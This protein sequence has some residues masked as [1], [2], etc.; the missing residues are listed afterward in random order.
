MTTKTLA[1]VAA[2]ILVLSLG[3]RS[4]RAADV[5]IVSPERMAQYLVVRD[6]SVQNDGTVSGMAVNTSSQPVRDA[7]LLIRHMFLWKNERH[8]GKNDPSQAIY[9]TVPQEIPP[10]GQVAFTVRP[11]S[12]LPQRRDGRFKSGAEVAAVT[13]VSPGPATA[14]APSYAPPEAGTR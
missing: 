4:V 5:V 7:H 8:P 12:P 13:Q 9:Y 14:S 3:A 11:E 2:S 1:L 6:V 10:G